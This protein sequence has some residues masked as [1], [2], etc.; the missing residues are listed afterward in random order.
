MRKNDDLFDLIKSLSK[1]EK[2]YFKLQSD[3]G[4][5][6]KKYVKIFESIDKMKFYDEGRLIK[7]L[8]NTVIGKG[9]S[10]QKSYLFGLILKSL[11]L[12]SEQ[13]SVKANINNLIIEAEILKNRMM[14]EQSLK[15][16]SKAKKI[17]LEH[18]EN[19]EYA[20]ALFL[21][22]RTKILVNKRN[23]SDLVKEA[24]EKIKTAIEVKAWETHQ[25]LINS[26]LLLETNIGDL[27]HRDREIKIPSLSAHPSFWER[28]YYLSNKSMDSFLDQSF[29]KAFQ[30][31]E[32]LIAH[33]DAHPKIKQQFEYFYVIEGNNYLVA[34]FY[35][36][37]LDLL[38]SFLKE[39]RELDLNQFHLKREVFQITYNIE[40]IFYINSNLFGKAIDLV[41][42]IKEGLDYFGKNIV[43]STRLTF[44][45]N[46]AVLFFA[47]ERYSEALDWVNEILE[48]E[49]E[50]IRKDLQQFARIFQLIIHYELDND[51][52]L[53]NLITSAR[54]K[55]VKSGE[56]KAFENL[57]LSFFREIQ[58]TVSTKEEIKAFETLELSLK[59]LI[60]QPRQERVGLE[61]VS[62][63]IKSKIHKVSFLEAMKLN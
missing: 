52:I 43:Q 24:N 46:L 39:L 30:A 7:D 56:L 2:R 42:K 4:A 33:W 14:Y 9:L 21:E 15:Y 12:Y 41:P 53:D 1:S 16:V 13:K 10:A 36:K 3:L 54:R 18:Q 62:I 17:A 51:R 34:C 27:K 49:K 40:L 26:L 59:E 58:T 47:K 11:R 29:D 35:L 44:Y 60:D 31:S 48:T 22:S 5:A 8:N 63:W 28:H 61:E 20:R 50:A 38:L 57:L 23:I 37:R 19:D 25:A 6:Q 32:E 45:H 55:F